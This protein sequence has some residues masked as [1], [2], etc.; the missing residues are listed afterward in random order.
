MLKQAIT[1]DGTLEDWKLSYLLFLVY[2]NPPTIWTK[3]G[4]QTTGN[5]ACVG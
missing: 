4:E 5:L 3:D 1:V 2:K